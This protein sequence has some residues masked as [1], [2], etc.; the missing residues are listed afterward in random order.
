MKKIEKSVFPRT[1][2][3]GGING[4]TKEVFRAVK[5][6]GMIGIIMIDKCHY[7]PAQTYRK[8]NSKSET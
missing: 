5:I 4:Q 2:V 7:T 8:Y 6:P 3:E 1:G